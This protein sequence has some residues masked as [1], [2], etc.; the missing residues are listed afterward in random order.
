MHI[1]TDLTPL[2]TFL[3]KFMPM[4]LIK[5][6]FKNFRENYF[7]PHSPIFDLWRHFDSQNDENLA[8][9]TK[10]DLFDQIDPINDIFDQIYV[11]KPDWNNS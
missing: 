2:M 9:F 11:H 7:S 8:I 4:N 6:L 5:I 1:L 3:T 10:S